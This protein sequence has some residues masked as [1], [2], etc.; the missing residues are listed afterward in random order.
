[1]PVLHVNFQ[2]PTSKTDHV[3]MS[4]LEKASISPSESAKEITRLVFT[5]RAIQVVTFGP[6]HSRKPPKSRI[7]AWLQLTIYVRIKM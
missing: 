4:L 7:L 6:D 3:Q 2:Q 5:V 1:V